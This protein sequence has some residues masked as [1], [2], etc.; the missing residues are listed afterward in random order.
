MVLACD[1]LLL[2]RS[3]Q[4]KTGTETGEPVQAAPRFT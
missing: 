3:R 2:E 4:V 1:A